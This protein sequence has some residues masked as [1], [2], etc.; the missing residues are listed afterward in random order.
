[1]ADTVGP[2]ATPIPVGVQTW[3]P[4]HLYIHLTG[5]IEDLKSSLGDLRTADHIALNAALHAAKDAVAAALVAVEKASDKNDREV[6]EWRLNSN[7]W[8]AA[9]DDREARFVQVATFE[10]RLSGILSE[11]KGLSQKIEDL[12]RS[13]DLEAGRRAAQTAIMGFALVALTIALRF[14]GI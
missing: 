10:A 11:V 1:M 3:S 2:S 6:K 5:K 4:E 13:R 9:M 7:E 14:L 8:R 12:T